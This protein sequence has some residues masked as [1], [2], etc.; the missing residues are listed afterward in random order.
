MLDG[1]PGPE[2]F[3]A[4]EGT[5]LTWTGTL[6]GVLSI[7]LISN[8]SEIGVTPAIGTREILAETLLLADR[9]QFQFLILT[10]ATAQ[11]CRANHK[12]RDDMDGIHSLI[13]HIIP[14][15]YKLRVKGIRA[16]AVG[17]GS[18]DTR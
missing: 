14:S 6:V 9:C 12:A 15:A 5:D 4:K 2:V 1:N 3:A 18:K 17:V 16:D 8:I 13:R 7:A 10:G 11:D